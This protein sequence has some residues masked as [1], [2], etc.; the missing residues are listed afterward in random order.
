PPDGG[1]PQF[2]NRETGDVLQPIENVPYVS[3][4]QLAST[5][6]GEY[7]YVIM[8]NGELRVIPQWAEATAPY[9]G[10]FD[11]ARGNNVIAGGKVWL[12]N[13]VVQKFNNYSGH[14]HPKGAHLE[15]LIRGVFRANNLRG[16]NTA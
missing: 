16:A 11:T 13:G 7:I 2:T 4:R 5:G 3:L 14:Y 6:S 12:E 15:R 10:H 8:P 1:W 9:M